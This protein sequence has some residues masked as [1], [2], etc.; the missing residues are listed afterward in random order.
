ME[1][2]SFSNL[3]EQKCSPCRGGI[4][5]MSPEDIQ[6]CLDQISEGWQVADNRKLEKMFRFK[7]FTEALAFTNNVGQLAEQQQHH[8][9]I[10]LAWGKVKIELW[11][12]K[13]GGLHKNDFILA[14]GIDKLG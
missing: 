11:T 6:S 10:Y 1:N 5:P 14:A 9:D 12:H 7:N 3:S 8:P 13:I 2:T 4:E